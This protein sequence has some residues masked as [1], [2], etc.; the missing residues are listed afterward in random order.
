MHECGEAD[1][2][3]HWSARIL[4]SKAFALGVVVA[5]LE[6]SIHQLLHVHRFPNYLANCQ[7]F[8]GVD[9]VATTEFIGCEVK[10][11]SDFVHVSFQRKNGLR[12]AEATEGAMRRMISRQCL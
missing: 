8:A 4:A 7:C 11:F 6:G 9:E 12:S 5:E 10:P 2:S 1:T 3:L